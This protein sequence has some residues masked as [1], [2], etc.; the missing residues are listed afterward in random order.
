MTTIAYDGRY[1]AADSL[2]TRPTP[3]KNASCRSC[4]E[5]IDRFTRIGDK[6]RLPSHKG[7]PTLYKNQ[8]VLA[9]AS[10]GHV[11][12]IR[13]LDM[14]IRSNYSLALSANMIA[15]G[16]DNLKLKCQMIVLTEESTWKVTVDEHTIEEEMDNGFLSI[17]SGSLLADYLMSARDMSSW[18][19]VEEVIRYDS[20]SGGP[21]LVFDRLTGKVYHSVDEEICGGKK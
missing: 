7:A 12:L 16:L 13:G 10:A 15:A 3:L 8:K 17:G 14:A 6:I 4:G 18:K 2:T 20:G 21:V 1:L 11:A 5:P 19:A 9:W